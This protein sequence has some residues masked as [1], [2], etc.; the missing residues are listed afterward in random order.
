MIPISVPHIAGNE[1]K[2]VKECLDGEWVSSVGKYVEKFEGDICRSTQA[3]YAI[4]CVNGTAALHVALQL[5]GVE[6][7]DEVIVPTVTFIAPVNVVRYLFA[8]PVFM[9]CDRFYNIDADKVAEYF[10]KETVFRNGCTYNRKTNKCIRAIVPVHVFGNAVRMDLL[11]E[12]CEERNVRIVEDATESLGSYYSQ[13]DLKGKYTGA[14]GDIGC[15]SFNGNKIITTGG[16]GMLVTNNKEYADKARYLTTQAK[17]DGVHY[18]HNEVGY[19][20]RLTNIQAA[21]GV[22]QLEKLAEFIDIK[23]RNYKTYKQR[24][25]KI[26]G[27]HLAEIPDYAFSNCWYYC[28]RIDR[29]RYGLDRESLMSFLQK[30]GV[31]T[32]PLWQLNHL[33]KPYEKCQAYR[34]E[35]AYELLDNTLNIPC[36]VNLT[37]SQ[38]DRVI[39]LLSDKAS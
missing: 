5:V 19:N 11:K 15:F 29:T 38:I 23:R 12:I 34:I 36:S 1:W 26:S 22:A 28:V 14:V 10:N 8:E 25:D 37:L 17:D 3:K 16:G 27:L 32:R 24:I 13:G 2:Y 18:V 6:P 9:D 33:Q 35:R 39:D 31:Q 30:E 20:Y 21:M 7:G 4:A